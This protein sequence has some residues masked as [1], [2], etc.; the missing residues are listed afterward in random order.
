MRYFFLALVLI[1]TTAMYA[2]GI[3]SIFRA[4]INIS[5]FRGPLQ[6]DAN[7]QAVESLGTASGFHIGAGLRYKIDYEEK[8][9][10]SLE[11]IYSQKG[12]EVNYDG[13]SYFVFRD[14]N[15]NRLV[16]RGARQQTLNVTNSYIDIP[17][18]VYY[19]VTKGIELH[20]GG[21]IGFLTRSRGTGDYTFT[22]QTPTP[23]TF[24]AE[25]QHNYRGDE[26]TDFSQALQGTLTNVQ[27]GGQTFQ[28]PVQQNAYFEY[29]RRTGN[30]YRTIDYGLTGGISLYLSQGLYLGGRIQYGMANVVRNDMFLS[31][32]DVG[33]GN[34]LVYR[35]D[36]RTVL[37]YQISIGFAF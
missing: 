20:A 16:S 11:L 17:L 23:A 33:P 27:I 14:I 1:T 37:N 32:Y 15:N 22:A 35:E 5:S 7:G 25:L 28:V 21:Y 3:G 26:L 6:Q 10:V 13:A 36:K 12:G 8:L 19:K 4:G 9:G 34:Q 31:L 30:L 18:T 24:G 2:Q 29:D